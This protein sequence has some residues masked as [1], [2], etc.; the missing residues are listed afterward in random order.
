MAIPKRIYIGDT[1]LETP[2][3]ILRRANPRD[4]NDFYEYAKVDGVGEMAGWKHHENIEESRNILKSFIDEQCV[5]VIEYKKNGKMIGTVGVHANDFA[6]NDPKLKD[7]TC[8]EIGYVLSKD[9]WGKGITPE[10]VYAVIECCFTKFDIDFLWVG[11]FEGNNQSKRVIEKCGFTFVS[12]DEYNAPALNKTFK[13]Y[14]YII[15]NPVRG[16]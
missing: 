6:P 7:L 8:A 11:H 12:E 1:L 2:R 13:C 9:Y 4:L 5:F 10:A 15:F 14:K 3:L 16:L